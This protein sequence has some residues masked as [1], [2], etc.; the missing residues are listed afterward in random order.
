MHC[1]CLHTHK[2]VCRCV[3]ESSQDM[4]LWHHWELRTHTHTHACMQTHTHTHFF[5][6]P[7]SET[8]ALP[9]KCC[10]HIPPMKSSPKNGGE[11]KWREVAEKK[12]SPVIV[13]WG[14]PS[15]RC[16][17]VARSLPHM[18]V[19]G[20]FCSSSVSRSEWEA[21]RE[22]QKSLLFLFLVLVLASSSGF[23]HL[24]CRFHPPSR[25]ILEQ[26]TQG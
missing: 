21:F 5:F 8:C 6:W 4:R 7:I 20:D 23:V 25:L 22:W 13:S 17:S 18:W 10:L 1:V 15:S 2:L 3:T 12:R 19:S 9:G 11:K 14:S 16:L 26:T 24:D